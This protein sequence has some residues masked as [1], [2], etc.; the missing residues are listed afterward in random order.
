MQTLHKIRTASLFFIFCLLFGIA[1]VNL[2]FLQIKQHS[3]FVD[4]AK[5]QYACTVTTFH[6]RASIIDRNGIPLALNKETTSAFIMPRAIKEKTKLL[7]FLEEHFPEAAERYKKNPHAHF[8][9]IKRKL[10][11]EEQ[12]LLEKSSLIDIHF[13]HEP[14]RYYPLESAGSLTGITDIDNKGLF[15]VELLC[16]EQLTGTPTTAQIE[17]DARSGK[18]YFSKTTQSEGAPGISLAL[19]IDAHLQFLVHEELLTTLEKFQAQEGAALVMDP[20][21]GDLLALASYPSFDPNNPITF[22]DT[23]KNRAITESYE[24][25]SLLKTFCALAALEEHVVEYDEYIDCLNSKSA[26]VDGRKVNNWEA[27]G[28]VPFA[29][30][31]KRSNNIGIAQIAKR[32]DTALYEHYLRLGFG[33]KTGV[34]FPGE[35][36]GFVMPPERWSKQSIISLSY[37]YEITST[38]LQ[39][40]RAFCIFANDGHLIVPRLIKDKET[41]EPQKVYS[42]QSINLMRTILEETTSS[43]GTGKKAA[44]H[45]YTTLGKTSTTNL[46]KNGE[47]DPTKNMYGFAGIIEKGDYKRVIACFVKEAQHQNLYASTVAAPLFEKIAERMLMHDKILN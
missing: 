3:F 36:S 21:T 32:L 45:G 14:S 46:L 44:I 2:Y 7:L 16:N 30:V 1:L 33:T 42:T 41:P 37:G 38:L 28:V 19:T 24:F 4:L 9:Y 20:E 23:T 22:Q 35:Q 6:P 39:I 8:S 18:F 5:Q 34:T 10:S 12:E 47:Y 17:K 25:G 15:G 40:A 13:L 43:Q 26:Y 31:I 29:D 11:S 27:L